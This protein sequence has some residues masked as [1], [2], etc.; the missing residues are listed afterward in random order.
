MNFHT[1]S[2]SLKMIPFFL[3]IS[4]I[5]FGVGC[6]DNREIPLRGGAEADDFLKKHDHIDSIMGKCN[7]DDKKDLEKSVML[8]KNVIDGQKNQHNGVLE[9]RTK[10]YLF[11]LLVK[12]EK[13]K[14]A[15]KLEEDIIDSLNRWNIDKSKDRNYNY[16]ICTFQIENAKILKSLLRSMKKKYNFVVDDNTLLRCDSIIKDVTDKVGEYNNTPERGISIN[17]N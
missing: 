9:S 15:S 6:R 3:F 7:F 14:D 12:L 17:G 10:I 4:L 1:V 5:M 16:W 13:N 11:L 8:L 2:N